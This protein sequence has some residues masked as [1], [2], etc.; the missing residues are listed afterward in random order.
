MQVYLE[1]GRLFLVFKEMRAYGVRKV[2]ELQWDE[3]KMA[4]VMRKK[5]FKE[6][7]MNKVVQIAG[8]TSMFLNTE[9]QNINKK[10]RL[11]ENR[12]SGTFVR[13][14]DYSS[15]S[16]AASASAAAFFLPFRLYF[17]VSTMSAAQNMKKDM[18]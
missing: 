1:M 17:S 16:R 18:R 5:R 6:M 9:C 4:S 13:S 8:S 14:D 3:E 10:Y 7:L 12:I 2:Y 11:S 15:A